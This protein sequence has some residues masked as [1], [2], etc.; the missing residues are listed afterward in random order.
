[1]T[2]STRF[3]LAAAALLAAG[4]TTVAA[5]EGAPVYA[6]G[7][8]GFDTF[9]IPALCVTAK[10]ALLAFA[11]RS[12]RLTAER[13]EELA[14]LLPHLARSEAGPQGAARLSCQRS[15]R[16]SRNAASRSGGC[17]RASA[18]ALSCAA[19]SS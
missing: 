19:S 12:P 10:G 4:R 16:C 5:P 11:E 9:R 7:E 17:S 8:N 3:L 18:S 1:M 6:K 2:F 14:A 15:A 13:Q